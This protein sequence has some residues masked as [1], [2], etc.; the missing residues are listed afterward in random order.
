MCCIYGIPQMQ[1]GKCPECGQQIGG[2]N[3]TPLS[4][5]AKIAENERVNLMNND[6]TEVG[7][8]DDMVTDASPTRHL[9]VFGCEF[10]R[11]VI[12]GLLSMHGLVFPQGNVSAR[13]CFVS[14]KL[15]KSMEPKRMMEQVV[16]VWRNMIK[17]SQLPESEVAVSVFLLIQ[18]AFKPGQ[19]KNDRIFCPMNTVMRRDS[20][21][22]LLQ[23]M[24]E[25]ILGDLR[26]RKN[27]LQ[28]LQA[29]EGA[30]VQDQILTGVS[31]MFTVLRC[32]SSSSNNNSN[33]KGSNNN[34]K[35]YS[36]DALFWQITPP[37][38]HNMFLRAFQFNNAN[39]VKYKLLSTFLQVEENLSLIKYLADI[40]AWHALLFE[41][42]PPFSISREQAAAITNEQVMWMRD[43][44]HK[45]YFILLYFFWF[46]K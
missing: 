44:I 29:S 30:A 45:I 20:F 15:A 41:V 35:A 39:A 6:K 34:N 38:L 9:G 42:F 40:L 24:V 14:P 5:N 21:E 4:G 23:A 32:N 16:Q 25:P 13:H 26:M 3:H 33:N 1:R 28:E 17:V 27:A 43:S 11:F 31:K 10:V 22:G 2:A 36:M 46:V 37:N 12:F 18:G 8:V 7:I 19:W